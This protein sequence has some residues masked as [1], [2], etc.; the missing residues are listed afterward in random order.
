[1]NLFK[2]LVYNYSWCFSFVVMRLSF[3]FFFS[4]E[5]LNFF[6]LSYFHL[7]LVACNIKFSLYRN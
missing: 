2:E 3:S 4:K 5:L 7:T 1:M 6:L